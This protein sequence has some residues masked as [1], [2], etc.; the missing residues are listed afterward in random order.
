M[1]FPFL[2]CFSAL[3]EISFSLN[4]NQWEMNKCLLMGLKGDIKLAVEIYDFFGN[5]LHRTYWKLISWL[6][7]GN[8]LEFCIWQNFIFHEFSSCTKNYLFA[9]I[10]SVRFS[11]MIFQLC[12]SEKHVFF[13]IKT[14]K[15]FNIFS[16]RLLVYKSNHRNFPMKPFEKFFLTL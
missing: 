15:D 10:F 2:I 5:W 9:F 13:W 7:T 4:C 12:T 8:Y 11:Q 14:F 6:I 1:C 16:F 3:Y